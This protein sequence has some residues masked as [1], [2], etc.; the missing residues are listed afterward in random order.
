MAG[1]PKKREQSRQDRDLALREGLSRGGL[2]PAL[3]QLAQRQRDAQ[4]APQ[5]SVEG[6]GGEGE[7]VKTREQIREETLNALYP[8]ARKVIEN[9]L[10]GGEVNREQLTAAF[11]V[12]EQ[13]LGRPTQTTEKKNEDDNRVTAIVYEASFIDP[14]LLSVRKPEKDM[15]VVGT[16]EP[17][18]EE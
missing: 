1:M 15:P 18:A 14:H 12:F 9:A 7:Q 8:Q 5:V 3:R 10:N 2:N 4:Q 16:A 11:R 6:N 17:D 13:Q